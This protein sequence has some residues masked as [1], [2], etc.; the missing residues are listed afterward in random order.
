MSA[1]LM[2]VLVAMTLASSIAGSQSAYWVWLLVPATALW[3][4][5]APSSD[6]WDA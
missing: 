1:S 5:N 6:L 3:F 4:A 2:H